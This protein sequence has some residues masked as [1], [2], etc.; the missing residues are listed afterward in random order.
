MTSQL[1][2]QLRVPGS[3][4]DKQGILSQCPPSTRAAADTEIQG[5]FQSKKETFSSC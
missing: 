1:P 3:N 5:I 4:Q 2:Q